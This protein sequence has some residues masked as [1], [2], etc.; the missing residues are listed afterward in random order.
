MASIPEEDQMKLILRFYF[1]SLLNK[2][3]SLTD[4]PKLSELY[5]IK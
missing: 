4:N 2:A 5:F 3:Y 1:Q